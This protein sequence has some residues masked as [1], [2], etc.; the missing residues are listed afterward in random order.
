MKPSNNTIRSKDSC[1]RRT[2]VRG[3]GNRQQA[4]AATAEFGAAMIVLA[5]LIMVVG[6][7]AVEVAQAY[8][9][10][11]ALYASAY[12]A[13]RQLSIA[14]TQNAATTMANPST[15]FDNVTYLN[16]VTSSSQFS[17]PTNGWNESSY[18]HS[19]TVI[20]AYQSG[21]NGSPRFPN[22]DPLNLGSHF[23]LQAQASFYLY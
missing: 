9:I 8:A 15:V 19:V 2:S 13:A 11:N 12:T 5:P 3:A 16:I 4:G 17:I 18:P 10:Y 21:Q 1:F 20:C 23:V 22:P 6:Y 14:Y 7:V